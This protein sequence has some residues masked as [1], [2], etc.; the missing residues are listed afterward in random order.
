MSPL[1]WVFATIAFILAVPSAFVLIW[2]IKE[3]FL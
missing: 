1:E 2:L 3:L